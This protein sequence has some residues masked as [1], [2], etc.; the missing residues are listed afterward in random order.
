MRAGITLVCALAMCSL[1][2]P[3][4]AQTM[5][6][7]SRAPHSAAF[8]T[9]TVP[10]HSARYLTAAKLARG[11]RG[12]CSRGSG[13][14]AL[15]G[16]AFV[17]EQAGWE[18]HTSPGAMV[19]ASFTES[20]GGDAACGGNPKNIWGLSSCGSGWYVPYFR[21]WHQAFVFFARFLHRQWPGARTVYDFPGYSACDSCWGPRTA[22]WASR[23]GFGPGL[24]YP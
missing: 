3:G 7:P 24:R 11:L 18:T 2:G 15:A 1:A 8:Y 13:G 21:T 17:I 5:K 9:N 12:L 16:Q 4:E 6:P 20:S 10:R 22:L 14:C 23:L 19:G